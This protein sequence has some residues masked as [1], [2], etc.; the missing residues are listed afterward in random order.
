[1]ER[2]L[3]TFLLLL[4]I[5]VA[6]RGQT[7]ANLSAK[8][9]PVTSYEV[10]PGI[11]MTPKYAADGLVCE[12]VLE[13]RHK[14]E[15]GI[16]FG[17]LLSKEV[18]KELVDE[19]V[20]ETERGKNLTEFLNTTIDGGFVTTE[21]AYQN[22]L[23]R[24]HGITRPEPSGDMVVIITWRKRVCSQQ[25]QPATAAQRSHGNPASAEANA[26]GRK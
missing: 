26:K 9:R 24:V 15:T 6:A 23:V 1:M 8:Y 11:L 22:V 17:D 10:R 7:S 13:R 18:V 12:M 14:T 5:A 21:Y 20:P 25:V 4:S 16:N 19:L 3:F 2:A